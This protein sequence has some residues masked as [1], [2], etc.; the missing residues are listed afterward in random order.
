MNVLEDN[1]IFLIWLAW[2]LFKFYPNH[3]QR[4]QSGALLKMPPPSCSM[5]EFGVDIQK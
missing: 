3:K 1:I 5:E 4:I 2:V